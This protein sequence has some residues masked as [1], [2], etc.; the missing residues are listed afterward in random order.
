MS[1]LSPETA[2]GEAVCWRRERRQVIL[3]A[4]RGWAGKE[5]WRLVRPVSAQN[6]SSIG[7]ENLG[8]CSSTIR[9]T[10]TNLQDPLG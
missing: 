2:A 4:G 5:A 8:S 6:G 10:S 3:I 1:G 7:M 9:M